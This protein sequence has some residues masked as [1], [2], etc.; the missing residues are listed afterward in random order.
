MDNDNTNN[1]TLE[2][3][4]RLANKIGSKRYHKLTPKDLAEYKKYN[5]WRYINGN[6]KLGTT[7]ESKNWVAQHSDQVCPICGESY[8]CRGG[9]TI[10]HKLPRARYPWLSMDFQNFWVIC[11]ACNQEK[12]ERDWFEYELYI[13]RNYPDSFA[14]IRAARPT[15]LLKSLKR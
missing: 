2:E 13:Y 11:H 14:F 6:P 9:K 1:F 12:G 7:Q 5:E 4:F 10:D 3:L 8:F 15:L